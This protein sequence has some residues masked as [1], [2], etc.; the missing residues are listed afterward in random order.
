MSSIRKLSA[1]SVK[2]FCRNISVTKCWKR[3]SSLS[4]TVVC[5]SVDMQRLRDR[6]TQ[7]AV[8]GQQL[9]KHVPEEANLHATIEERCFLCGPCREIMTRTLESSVEGWVLQG[10]LRSDGVV[11]QFIVQSWSVNQPPRRDHRSWRVFIVKI[12]YQETTIHSRLRTLSVCSI[13]L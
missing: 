4:D 1:Y 7:P 5:T 13:D 3:K 2:S 10:R 12:R 9:R 6:R 11:F 8:S